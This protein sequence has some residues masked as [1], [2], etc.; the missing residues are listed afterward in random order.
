MPP[1]PPLLVQGNAAVPPSHS[2]SPALSFKV[3]LHPSP[4]CVPHR[5]CRPP[6]S[7]LFSVYDPLSLQLSPNPAPSPLLP[8]T[9][10]S[11]PLFPAFNPF[12]VPPSPQITKILSPSPVPSRPSCIGH[13]SSPLPV[14]ASTCPRPTP[15]STHL[16][17]LPLLRETLHPTNPH[18]PL[19]Q[20]KSPQALPFPNL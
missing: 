8:V 6:R 11:S 18:C 17:L 16:H 5:P 4:L 15:L 14:D 19:L 1:G 13:P 10:P 3:P 20:S 2:L 12:A 7:S 9:I